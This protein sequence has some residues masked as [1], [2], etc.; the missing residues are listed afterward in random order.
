VSEKIRVLHLIDSFWAGGAERQFINLVHGLPRAEFDVRLACFRPEG[1]MRD[2]VGEVDHYPVRGL[3]NAEALR[4]LLRMARYLRRHRIDVLHTWTLGPN[5]FGSVAGALA[6]TPVRVASVRDMGTVWG[7]RLGRL[8]RAA[9]RLATAVVSNAQAIADE[10]AAQGYDPRRLAV[11]RNGVL[12]AP[13]EPLSLHA[14]LGLA[15][16]VPLVAVVTRLHPVK[17]LHDF[18]AAAGSLAARH[19]RA[20]FLVIGT[21]AGDPALDRMADELREQAR[22]LGFGDRFL[23]TGERPDVRRLLGGLAVSVLTSESEGLSN[24][25]IES[26]ASGVPTVATRVG[27]NPEIVEEGV[28]GFLVPVGDPAALA[29]AID[30]VLTEPGLAAELGR[31]ARRR[32]DRLFGYERMIDETISLYLRLLGARRAPVAAARLALRSE[33]R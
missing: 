9:C 22:A 16:D 20:R 7:P 4:Q 33:C 19:P 17:R 27:G 3:R 25:L 31:N 30:R 18:V 11:I 6:R 13:A 26:M 12:P 1:G 14:E 5:V 32:F 28:T 24:A 2:E 29:A 8:Q 23:L 15:S 10:L 21:S